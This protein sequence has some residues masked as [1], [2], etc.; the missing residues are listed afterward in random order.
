MTKEQMVSM[1][2]KKA[3]FESRTKSEEVFEAILGSIHEQLCAGDTVILRN[4]GTFQIAKRSAR[5]GR[6]PRTGEVIT[7][8]ATTSVR[9]LPGKSL[10]QAALLADE[11]KQQSWTANRQFTKQMEERLQEIKTAIDGY[12]SKG[13]KLGGDAKKVYQESVKPKY[14]VARLKFRL[15]RASSGDVWDEMRV[16]FERA[17]AELREA[18][19][20][21][22]KRI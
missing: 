16:G 21:A 9:F 18:Y 11:G 5:K 4:F 15:L 13:E 6:N 22:K 20:R 14:E 19:N 12:L 17:Y 3:E 1:I 2:Q 8:P 10:K 7:I